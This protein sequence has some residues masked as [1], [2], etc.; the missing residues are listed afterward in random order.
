A[1]LK[2]M[3]DG[4]IVV[5]KNRRIKFLNQVAETLTGWK[6]SLARD[7]HLSEIFNS[8]DEQTR[9]PID[10]PVTAVFELNSKVYV[11][12]HTLLISQDGTTILIGYSAAPIRD[13]TGEIAGVVVVFRD[14]TQRR[15]AEERNHAME[16]ARQLELQI[17]EIQRINQLKDDLLS[18]VSHELRTPLSNIKMAVRLL[19]TVLDQQGLLDPET[20]SNAQSMTRYLNILQEQCNQELAL[21]NDLL[22]MRAIEAEANSIE[23]TSI[24][25]Q[26][27]IPQF[28]ESFQA[29]IETQQQYLQLDLSPDIPPL[30]SEVASLTRILSELMHNACKYTPPGEQITVTAQTSL[31][32]T[33][34]RNGVQ[35]SVSNSGVA[36]PQEELSRIF[37]PFYRI[38]KN[39]PWRQG[40]TGLGL[41]LVRKLV[42]RLQGKIEVTTRQNWI[43]FTLRIPDLKPSLQEEKNDSNE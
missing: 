1:I 42:N 27:W 39:D 10:D 36:I 18:T 9:Q 21:V 38:P 25:L 13:N 24:R 26:D 40:G 37:D 15:L 29:R 22:D 12:N 23:L 7:R 41:S 6:L 35:I 43:T 2:G 11:E 32:D 16:R 5:D 28:I 20:I 30:V 17:T 34:S 31:A 3:G 33:S 14:M 8:I 4:V 19:E